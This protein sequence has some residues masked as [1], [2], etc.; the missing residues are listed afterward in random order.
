[1]PHDITL[2]LTIGKRPQELRQTLQGLQALQALTDFAQVV[3]INDFGDEATSQA[4]QSLCPQGLLL[5]PGRQGHHKAVDTLYQHI[6][7]PYVFHCEDDWAF[8]SLPDWAA[9]KRLL[10]ARPELTAVCLRKLQD[11]QLTPEE[12]ARVRFD[13]QQGLQL[14]YLHP[15]HE[16]WHGY[17]FNPHLARMD[18]YRALAPFARFGKERHISRQF[19][20]QGRHVAYLQAGHCQHIGV[21]SVS[22]PLQERWWGRFKRWLR[23]RS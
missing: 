17:T 5:N 10:Q 16:Q 22:V 13:E 1:M 11:F 23:G 12:L 3:A 8:D 21:H 9:L 15:L 18:T 19:R 2:C 20:S 14:A 6:R 7:T 4:F